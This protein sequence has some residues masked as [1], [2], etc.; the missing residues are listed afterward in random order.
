MLNAGKNASCADNNLVED[1]ITPHPNPSPQLWGE[2][3]LTPF[4]TVGEGSGMGYLCNSIRINF[5]QI[6]ILIS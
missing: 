2:G 3:L 5:L 4:P 1:F 6:L